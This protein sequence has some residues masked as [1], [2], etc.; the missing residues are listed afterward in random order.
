MSFLRLH[1]LVAYTLC[2]LGLL[3]LTFGDQLSPLMSA[4]LLVA[5]IGS[6][7]ADRLWSEGPRMRQRA[8]ARG[9]TWAVILGFC[10][11]M[12]RGFWGGSPLTLG[13]EFVAWLT[14]SRLYHRRSAAE[15]RQLAALSLL[16]LMAATLLSTELVYAFAFVGFV[17]VL[18][19]M[20]SLTQLRADIEA[21]GG[22]SER[23]LRSTRLVDGRFLLSVAGLSLPL[24]AMTG[25]LFLAFPRVGFG[26]LSLSPGAGVRV[27]GFGRRVELG[28]FGAIRR[29]PTVVLRVT[30]P[31][32]L[33][34]PPPALSL[35]MR[36][37]SFDHYDGRRWT[38]SQATGAS[39][40]RRYD[41]FYPIPERLP[42]P[43][44]DRPYRIVLDHLDEPVLFLPPGTVGLQ[45]PPRVETGVEVGRR[46]QLSDGLDVRYLDA[47]GLGLRYT[48]WVTPRAPEAPLRTTAQLPTAARQRYLQ[49]PPGHG[50]V[51]ALGRRW[52]GDAKGDR[53]R[54]AL[55]LGRLKHGAYAYSLSMPELLRKNPLDV[56]LFEAR[57]GHCEYFSTALAILLRTQGI[58]ARN[59]TGFWGGQ[60]NDYGRYYALQKGDAH[61]WVEVWLEGRWVT[62]DPTPPARNA[63]GPV[64]GWLS[65]FHD[66][67]DAMTIAW[68]NHI[69]GYDLGTQR[70][71][72]LSL[73]RLFRGR[74]S[75]GPPPPDGRSVPSPALSR[76]GSTMHWVGQRAGLWVGLGLL[77]AIGAAF[78]RRHRTK[79]I[80]PPEQRA[81][82]LYADLE[83][84]LAR[85]GR[86]RP[87]HVTPLAH[88]K[89]L[90]DE[91]FPAADLVAELT[92]RYVQARF[93]GAPL[94]PADLA[95][96]QQRL[97][98]G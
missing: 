56:F 12:L 6:L 88:A 38:R 45:V 36:G 82:R 11:Q 83:R 48:A 60:W 31:G 71:L 27:S 1:K 28:D 67:V 96:L 78:A 39:G 2:G 72:L 32:R 42:D 8:W 25:V 86:P 5:F 90:R 85:H 3:S 63:V 68:Q 37:T 46:I 9:L 17:I 41:D 4:L 22:G 52:V 7:W 16:Q 33:E 80:E 49:V 84:W 59:V 69:V 34:P 62:L 94:S 81:A 44:R 21:R 92:H 23:W 58:P 14:I 15:Y 70:T 97:R 87:P 53:E 73:R 35:R 74:P 91:G 40:T 10:V 47:D 29:D 61:S 43:R 30:P 95:Q 98:R 54:A 55:L 75:A 26:F 64:R 65:P 77:V 89:A 50:R 24:F 13:L 93:A 18:P 51:A 19:W 20:L 66:F 76:G 79:R 57:R